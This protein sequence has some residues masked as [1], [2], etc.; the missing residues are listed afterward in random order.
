MPKRQVVDEIDCICPVIGMDGRN[1]TV[2]NSLKMPHRHLK[3][4]QI[5]VN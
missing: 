3:R 4:S 2:V 1:I 5:G